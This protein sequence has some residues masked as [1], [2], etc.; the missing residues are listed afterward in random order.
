ME[1]RDPWQKNLEYA[2]PMGNSI[3]KSLL[4]APATNDKCAV[5]QETQIYEILKGVLKDVELH[6]DKEA[7]PGPLEWKN[8]W[9]QLTG[10][11]GSM[12]RKQ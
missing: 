5:D 12:A 6:K 1:R 10:A 7:S 3:L 9:R 11:M 2:T 4:G 8:A